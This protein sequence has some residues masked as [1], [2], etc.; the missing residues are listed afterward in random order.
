MSQLEGIFAATLSVIREDLSLDI[1]ATIEHAQHV[2]RQGSG[3]AFLGST[4][5]SQLLP[6]QEKKRF[7]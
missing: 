5:Q 7:D 3:L 6:I 2:D 1:S 4:S